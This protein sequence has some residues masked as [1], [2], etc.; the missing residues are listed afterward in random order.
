MRLQERLKSQ[1]RRRRLEGIRD[2]ILAGSRR[3]LMAL[4]ALRWEMERSVCR[5]TGRAGKGGYEEEGL[6]CKNLERSQRGSV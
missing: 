3:S 4:K 5:G 1:E 2:E 6:V